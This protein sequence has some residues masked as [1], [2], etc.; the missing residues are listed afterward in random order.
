MGGYLLHKGIVEQI[1]L[2]PPKLKMPF[3]S[4]ISHYLICKFFRLGNRFQKSH[5][6]HLPMQF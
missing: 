5:L 2:K 1:P 6:L 3:I 4:V